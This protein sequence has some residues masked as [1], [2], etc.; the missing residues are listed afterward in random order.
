MTAA[1]RYAC[2]GAGAGGG[3]VSKTR[4]SYAINWD[5]IARDGQDFLVMGDPFRTYEERDRR[6]FDRARVATLTRDAAEKATRSSPVTPPLRSRPGRHRVRSASGPLRF[7]LGCNHRAVCCAAC[8]DVT[9]RFHFLPVHFQ[10][11]QV[12]EFVVAEG[13]VGRQDL[14]EN[15]DAT[16]ALGEEL[17]L[18][19]IE[20]NEALRRIL[21]PIAAPFLQEL[22]G[23]FLEN[24]AAEHEVRRRLIEIV[25]WDDVVVRVTMLEHEFEF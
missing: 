21:Q 22:A 13:A 3:L 8:R 5:S 10:D 1:G 9:Q 18:E 17:R 6:L 11:R 7:P 15:D 2:G 25:G 4:S 16:V 20:I 23:E 14:R 12:G 24:E 19:A